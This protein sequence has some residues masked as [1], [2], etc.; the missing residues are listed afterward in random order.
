MQERANKI[1]L[2]LR[3]KNILFVL[4]MYYPVDSRKRCEI[5][6]KLTIKT[7]ERQTHFTTFSS[8]SIV[9]IEQANVSWVI[10]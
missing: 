3:N 1:I 6:S 9:D 4:K 8:V 5:C 10:F 2:P 7:L